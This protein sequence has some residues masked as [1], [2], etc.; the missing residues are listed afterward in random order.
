V[1]EFDP[2]E[3]AAPQPAEVGD[4]G[5][6]EIIARYIATL[7]QYAFEYRQQPLCFRLEAGDREGKLLRGLAF[8]EPQL[9]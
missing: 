6:G 9:A 4:I 5:D 7:R 8:E 3:F 1:R 2:R